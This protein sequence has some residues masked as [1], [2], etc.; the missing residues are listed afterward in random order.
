MRFTSLVE[1]LAWLDRLDPQRIEL[2]L[3]RV[4]KV[5]VR[6]GVEAGSAQVI[7]VAGTNG[8]G[9][10]LAYL[11]T[12]LMTAGYRVGKYTSPHLVEF[13]ERI[14][15]AGMPVYE[16][17]LCAAFEQ[18]EEARRDV[19]L[20]YFEFTT[21]AALLIFKHSSLDVWLLEI[22]LGGR[23][24]AVNIIDPDC[25]IITNIGLDHTDW[26][27][28]TREA[29]ATEKAGILRPGIP[30]VLRQGYAGTDKGA[31]G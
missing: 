20:S 11:E 2:G 12:I 3:D 29:I 31:G 17:C 27:G 6:L 19:E 7:T 18:V 26:L 4:A 21:L 1:W 22:G 10:V 25:A 8:K 30:A 28:D 24:D 16:A 23:L 15:V 14:Q 5:T 9:S 13:N